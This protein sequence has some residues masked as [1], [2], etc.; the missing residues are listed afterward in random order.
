MDWLIN[1]CKE[2]EDFANGVMFLGIL[3]MIVIAIL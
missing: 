2:S 1:K 3:L